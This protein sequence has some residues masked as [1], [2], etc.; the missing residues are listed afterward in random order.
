M[1]VFHIKNYIWSRYV[2]F[3]IFV[4]LVVNSING[5]AQP[6]STNIIEADFSGSQLCNTKNFSFTNTSI[7][8]SGSITSSLWTFGD[9]NTSALLNP[10]HNYSAFGNYTV[11][12]TLT[13]SSGCTIVKTHN[14]Q[15][16]QPPSAQFSANFDS[17]CAGQ[18]IT[19]TNISTGSGLTYK[20]YFRDGPV[21]DAIS[22]SA[23]S[24]SHYFSAAV[25]IGYQTF[26]IKLEVID[27]NGCID[28]ITHPLVIKQRP[29]IDFL[30]N[31]NFRRCENVIGTVSDT[32]IIYNFSDLSSIASYQINWGDGGGFIPV[33]STFDYT[34]PVQHVYSVISNY[35]ISIQATGIN[36]CISTFR[37]TFEIITIP[38]PEFASLPFSAGCIP[39]TVYTVNNSSGVT[40]NT[41]TFINWGDNV[42]DT[43]ALGALPGDTLFHTYTSTTCINNSQLPYNIV[44][45]TKNECGAPFKSYGPVE[46][47]APP[48][49]HVNVTNDSMCVG[50][51]VVFLNQTIPNLC[52]A[53][54]RTLYTWNFGNAIVG[55]LLAPLNN[56]TP[57]ISHT[58]NQAGVYNVILTA[59]NTSPA[60]TGKPGC[61][62]TVDSIKVYIF[63]AYADFTFDTVCFGN[64]TQFTNLSTTPGGIITSLSWNF[65]DGNFSNLQNPVHT[66]ANPGHYNVKLT[67]VSSLGCTDVKYDTI[68][69]DSLPTA[70]FLITK[71]CLGDTT[72]FNNLSVAN[73]DSLISFLWDF[74]DGSSSVLKNPFHIYQDSGLYH[75]KLSVFNNKSCES[76]TTIS[77]SVYPNP[78]AS[79]YTDTVCSGY[80]RI[81]TNNSIPVA[82]SLISYFWNLGDGTGYSQQMDTT[83][84]YSGTGT[85]PVTLKISDINGCIDDTT[86]NVYLGPVPIAD[87]SFDTVCFTTHTHFTNTSNNQ[88]VPISLS[89]WDFGDTTTSNLTNPVHLYNNLSVFNVTLKVTNVNG[90]ID[91]ISKIVLLDTLPVPH[92]SFTTVCKGD[93]TTFN[94][95]SFAIG[96]SI[97]AWNWDF[98][99]GNS[100]SLQNPTHI[101]LNSGNYNVTLNVTDAKGCSKD[102][103]ITVT[104]LSLPQPSFTVT[105]PCKGQT[106]NFVPIA[107]NPVYNNW[108]WNFDN[109]NDTSLL[110]NPTYTFPQSITYNVKLE[111]IDANGCIGDTIQNVFISPLP[112]ANFYYDTVCYGDSTHLTNASID[113]GYAI[114]SWNWNFANTGNAN[115][116]NPSYLFN[117]A[118]FLTTTLVVSNI[119]GCLDTVVKLVRIDTIPFP[120]FSATT[121]CLGNTTHFTDFSTTS[122]AAINSWQWD[123]GDGITS[124][125]Q[126][127]QH[128]YGSP[129]VFN[130]N[131][132][133]IKSNGCNNDTTIGVLVHHLPQPVF[134]LSNVCINNAISFTAIDSL[135]PSISWQ[136]NFGDGNTDTV[137]QPFHTYS[138]SGNYLVHLHIVDTN[139]CEADTSK[140]I[141]ISTLPVANFSFDTNCLGEAISFI[142]LSVDSNYT[143]TAWNWNFG[144]TTTSSLQN[145]IHFYGNSGLYNVNMLVTNSNGC[146]DT[147]IFAVLVDTLPVAGF[148]ANNITIGGI[149]NFTEISIANS[150]FINSWNWDF[151]DGNTSN[152]QNPGH[153]YNQSDT[154]S[155]KLTVIN[156]NGCI[157]SIIN[158]I[159]VYPLPDPDFTVSPVCLGDSSHFIDNSLSTGGNVINWHWNFGDG[160]FI[161]LQN[162]SHKYT[163]AGN[164]TVWL[165]V[166]DVNGSIDSISHIAVVNHIP[167][168]DFVYNPVCSGVISSFIDSSSVNGS[169][170]TQWNWNFGDGTTV[171]TIQN[172]L[173]QYAV[174]NSATS[175]NVTIIVSDTNGCVDTLSKQITIY[176]PV[177]AGFISDTVCNN[178][179]VQLVDNSFSAAGNIVAWDWNFGNG[180]GVSNQQ[181]PVYTYTN[182]LNSTLFNVRLIVTDTLSCKDTV[183]NQLLVH[184]QPQVN[185]NADTIC[186]GSIT[187]FTDLTYSNGG[188]LSAWSWD[189]GG[190]GSSLLQNPTYTFSTWGIYNTTLTVTDVNGCSAF[191]MIPVTV[192]SIP[193]VN[194]TFQGNC[195]SGLIN[196]TDASF[197]HGSPNSNWNW[198]F[199]DSYSSTLQNPV[200]YYTA[201]DTFN[202]TLTVGNTA[203]CSGSATKQLYMN[204]SLSY[205]FYAD[206]ACAGGT[207]HFIDSFLIQT[208]QITTW[209]WNFGDGGIATIHNASHQY[210]NAGTYHVT[211]TVADTNGCVETIQHNIEV[212]P[213]PVVNFAFNYVCVG[214]STVFSDI[215]FSIAPNIFYSWD[216]GDG[217][218]SN[219]V[220]PVHLFDTAG[221]YTVKL[222]VTNANGCTDSVFKTVVITPKPVANF[223]VNNVC[224]GIPVIINDSTTNPGSFIN[225]WKWLFGDGNSFFIPDSA[226]YTPTITHAY[227]NAGNYTI[228]LIVKNNACTDTITKNIEI[229]NNPVA[230]FYTS[231]ECLNDTSYFF[232]TTLIAGYPIVSW[233][234]NFGDGV[235]SVLHNPGHVY[236]QA[237]FYTS[238]LNVV[239]SRGCSNTINN[240]VTVYPLPVANFTYTSTCFH[241]STHFSNLSFG[242]GATINYWKWI[243]GDATSTTG[244]ENPTHYYLTPKNYNVQFI[245]GNTRG[246]IDTTVMQVIVDSLPQANFTSNTVC[247]GSQ[248]IFS[249]TSVNHGSTNTS[250]KWTFGDGIGTSVLQNPF[251]TYQNHGIF[252]ARLLVKNQKGCVDSISKPVQVDTIPIANFKADSA[253][254]G[255]PTHFTNLSQSYGNLALTYT[256]NFGDNTA[257]SNLQN[258]IHTYSN[259]GNYLVSLTVTDAHSCSR[260]LIKNIVVYS[261]P[262]AAFTAPPSQFP[263]AINFA[264]NSIGNPAAIVSWN[265]NFGDGTGTS[266]LQN[267][268]YNYSIADTFNARLIV[269]D[270][271]GCKDTV[272]NPVIVYLPFINADF[273]FT[274]SCAGSSA[275]FTDSSTIGIGNT[276]LNW[277]W[278]FGDANF[279]TQ[280][281]PQHQ[282][283]NPGNYAVKLIV[284]GFGG[285]S[286]TIVKMV[287][288]YPKPIANFD[289]SGVC[290]GIN[291][292]FTNLSTVQTGNIISW[293]WNFGNG[294][295]ANTLNHSTVYNTF[296]NYNVQLIVTTDNGC[297]D[298]ITKVIKVNPLP[299][300]SFTSD[301]T[302]GCVPLFVSFKDSSVVDSGFIITWAWDFG[303]GATSVTSSNQTGHSYQI[304]GIYNVSVT[305]TSNSACSNSLQIPDMILVH[306]NPVADFFATPNMTSILES[307]IY[308]TDNSSNVSF[309][310]WY[311]GDGDS[312]HVQS[313]SHIY[314]EYGTYYPFLKV[315]SVQGCSD[316]I[317]KKIVIL[318]DATFYA[319]S[320]FT[321]NNDG[322]NDVFQVY[323]LGLEK[324]KFELMI[325]NRW[326]EMV[327]YSQDYNYGWNGNMKGGGETCPDGVYVWKL[328]YTDGLGRSQKANGHLTLI[329]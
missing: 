265:W 105:T 200:H 119:Y 264:N 10:S 197:P 29:F 109:N 100:S 189:F 302:E 212:N 201:V 25:G 306:P 206:T 86:I 35:P 99:D 203:G 126:N 40:P 221:N 103:I 288:V 107:G 72:F 142:D 314:N 215:T 135:H 130:V 115:I 18:L 83:Y 234:W 211:L 239:D 178:S 181:I 228:S 177:T 289:N 171:S 287:T 146:S 170:I 266:I 17:V 138:N 303:D 242:N 208:T 262:T 325:F 39:F 272:I 133:V 57:G 207:T 123:Y 156:S 324:G 116:A 286:D 296:G 218:Q 71:T 46:V 278:D 280:Q 300:V 53:N 68:I 269:T 256:W 263:A 294:N 47:Y 274:V 199:G 225:S 226:L 106:A 217:N 259:A 195:A 127:P 1:F 27:A 233:N 64:P 209:L 33:T 271:H 241:D 55:P 243:F 326:G 81:F 291:K 273:E 238:I 295:T 43:L 204:P 310:S 153:I 159:I 49:A 173:H 290:I 249:N 92:F 74:D 184:P 77:F 66:F 132:N 322:Y 28:S 248:T 78:I 192:D 179:A 7:I 327:F 125:L 11:T 247:L 110:Q 279:S 149:T 14:I 34:T 297:M 235:N 41:L 257:L 32:A 140:N 240:F 117:N 59:A 4:L 172:P 174:V 2:V 51:Q 145:P 147:A 19:F 216:F 267:P 104:V 165:I 111:V 213:R 128:T 258:P 169:I 223:M 118:G 281:N 254:L 36:G 312:S 230:G 318:K 307:I 276:I 114:N 98:G 182:V 6:C 193:D 328:N 282:Y 80:Q 329:R 20:W 113:S 79:F 96:S 252:N 84:I 219:S 283:A 323:G 236:A 167:A 316:T 50:N 285:T 26:E 220:N 162:P 61:G 48:D 139:Y 319:P 196:F 91:S 102:T 175:Y 275:F 62:S 129:G 299:V 67:I 3:F 250:W 198:D 52:A 95:L 21:Y 270:I 136:W 311:F 194:F 22:N 313:P 15:V 45:T 284:K 304:A 246:C 160:S 134:T 260:T 205:E 315:T 5:F 38:L 293:N 88:G 186:L 150:A 176:P 231:N 166:T 31:G 85:Y 73:A 12:L 154:F 164:Y 214:D 161:N 244:I 261:L 144:D 70:N 245:V 90:C 97:T 75:V 202:V 56:P 94:D 131:L 60:S 69:V 158:N 309:W 93:T 298:S 101:F 190:I 168:A 42:I 224:E 222:I 157:D 141:F 255:L 143:I 292:T 188:A 23:T 148:N 37:D 152:Q 251:Y 137:Q 301:I 76:D 191:K 112:V 9:G 227:A 320:G 44:L 155:V 183:Y 232:D 82:G 317:S 89:Y 151:G 187:V 163:I 24:P 229:Y 305:V 13:H 63:E 124:N 8:H 308:F 277:L 268:V 108:N 237:G 58:Y 16:L 30:E 185:F 122:G 210:N 321:P 253:C 121:V 87:F 180:S 54:P 65:G 120:D